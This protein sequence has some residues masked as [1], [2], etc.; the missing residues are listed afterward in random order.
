MLIKVTGVTNYT[1]IEKGP[2]SFFSFLKVNDRGQD[3]NAYYNSWQ[4]KTFT[5]SKSLYSLLQYNY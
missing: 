4:F 5:F 2:I 1:K 3:L